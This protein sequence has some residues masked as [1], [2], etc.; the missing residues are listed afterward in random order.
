MTDQLLERIWR[1]PVPAPSRWVSVNLVAGHI[2]S[3]VCAP[4]CSAVAGPRH[5]ASPSN[6]PAGS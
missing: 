5:P 2:S 6:S 3:L 1:I 4:G